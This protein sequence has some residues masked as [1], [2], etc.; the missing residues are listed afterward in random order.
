MRAGGLNQI[1]GVPHT[2]DLFAEPALFPQADYDGPEYVAARDK[3]R[4][5]NQSERI[6]R[7]M[8]DGVWRTLDEIS[9]ATGDPVASISAQLRHLRKP[10]FGSH[11]VERRS[12]R[13]AL[14]EYRLKTSRGENQPNA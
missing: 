2:L 11:T 6:F 4:L 12:R 13:G 5:L 14:F 7:L 9:K 1:L 3:P 8:T 10:R